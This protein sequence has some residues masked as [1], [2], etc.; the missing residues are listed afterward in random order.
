MTLLKD[1]SLLKDIEK[2]HNGA[3]IL[4]D[5]AYASDA[6]RALVVELGYVPVVL[7]KENRSKPWEHD[8]N[9]TSGTMKL[10]TFFDDLRDSVECLP[11]MINVISCLLVSFFL[12]LLLRPTN[13][14]RIKRRNERLYV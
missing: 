4:M 8:R 3:C 1:V 12:R 9:C 7:P 13:M 11:A 2:G 14:A 10:G 5:R 6:T